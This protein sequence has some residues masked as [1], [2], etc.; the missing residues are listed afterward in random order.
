MER[1]TAVHELWHANHETQTDDSHKNHG[2]L[3]DRKDGN[4][5]HVSIAI[6]SIV[7]PIVMVTYIEA[8]P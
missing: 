3:E 6:K 1:H 4:W 5:D 7:H 8:S 2:V